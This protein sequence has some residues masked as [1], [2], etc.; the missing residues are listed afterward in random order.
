[1]V[2]GPEISRL[3]NSFEE[4]CVSMS[5]GKPS[6]K[7]HSQNESEQKRFIK[8]VNSLL[9]TI[10]RYGNPFESS[11]THLV[12]LISSFEF[13]EE[14]IT[15]LR[16]L[17]ETGK[18]QCK[19]FVKNRLESHSKNFYEPLKMNNFNIFKEKPPRK[20]SAL[21]LKNKMLKNDLELFSRLYLGATNRKVNLD[22]FFCYENQPFPPSISDNGHLRNGPKS[23]IVD[24]LCNV[25]KDIELEDLEYGTH[26]D[27]TAFFLMEQLSFI[28]STQLVLK[29][30]MNIQ[31]NSKNI[32]L[33]LQRNFK[34]L[35]LYG[36]STEM[37]V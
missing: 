15:T 30:S 26:D 35:M 29:R 19:D 32:L 13:A 9:N 28:S 1:M 37:I 23:N 4:Q 16:S 6:Y 11:S 3:V 25:Y 7:H 33:N 8:D 24:C 2:S 17:A 27:A 10:E 31:Q 34:E 5:N 18:K 22:E 14:T 20:V 36:T 21:S 12:T